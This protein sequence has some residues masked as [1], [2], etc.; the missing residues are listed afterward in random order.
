M[1]KCDC[2]TS[3]ILF[4]NLHAASAGYCWARCLLQRLALVPLPTSSKGRSWVCTSRISRSWYTMHVSAIVQFWIFCFRPV[5]LLRRDDPRGSCV[6]TQDSRLLS[7]N[8]LSV[9]YFDFL[10]YHLFLS[11]KMSSFLN[12][13]LL[14]PSPKVSLQILLPRAPCSTFLASGTPLKRALE[15]RIFQYLVH[16]RSVSQNCD[17]SACAV[18]VPVL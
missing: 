3:G 9:R 15:F 6:L 11:C 17:W 8:L 14:R 10:G 18:P 12:L 1:C 2:P 7:L 4:F 16:G 5:G 13:P